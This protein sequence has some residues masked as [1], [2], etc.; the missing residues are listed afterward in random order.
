MT[1]RIMEPGNSGGQKEE[2]KSV[3]VDVTYQNIN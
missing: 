3:Q 2:K 1:E